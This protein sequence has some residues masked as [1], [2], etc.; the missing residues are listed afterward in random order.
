[1]LNDY[2][3]LIVHLFLF[4]YWLFILEFSL[5]DSTRN[6]YTL[7]LKL[8]WLCL[9]WLSFLLLVFGYLLFLCLW[10][11]VDY[12]LFV[13]VLSFCYFGESYSLIYSLFLEEFLL[14]ILSIRRDGKGVYVPTPNST[15]CGLIYETYCLLLLLFIDTSYFTPISYCFISSNESWLL[16]INF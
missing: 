11:K 13:F 15:F 6:S 3:L 10:A 16:S 5:L 12:N 9:S 2:Y 7:F 8:N 4:Y 14:S 1:M